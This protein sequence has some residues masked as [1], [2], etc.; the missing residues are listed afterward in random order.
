MSHRSPSPG[1]LI[2]S[3]SPP[4]LLAASAARVTGQSRLLPPSPSAKPHPTAAR[5]IFLKCRRCTLGGVPVCLN[6]LPRLP[7]ACRIKPELLSQAGTALV[8]WLP[9]PRPFPSLS[10]CQE[11]PT[12]TSG[13]TPRAFASSVPVPAPRP[14]GPRGSSR[15]PPFPLL[16]CAPPAHRSLAG[17]WLSLFFLPDQKAIP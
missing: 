15:P 5:G 2:S 16:P 1:D 17:F 13:V 4:R 6:T 8:T 14:P 9:K 7:A 12:V 3:R 10:S 11:S